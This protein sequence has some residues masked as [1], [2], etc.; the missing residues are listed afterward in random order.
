MILLILLH[1]HDRSL[2]S[3][4]SRILHRELFWLSSYSPPT[5]QTQTAAEVCDSLKLGNASTSTVDPL[6]A[7]V[8][9]DHISIILIRHAAEAVNRI[10]E[11][12]RFWAG[13]GF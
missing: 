3:F 9:L 6:V 13:N 8:T 11:E 7:A 1:K 2:A 5:A 12:L 4:L 10:G